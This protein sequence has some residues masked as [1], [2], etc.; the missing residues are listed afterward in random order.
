MLAG[1]ATYVHSSA[2]GA[3]LCVQKINITQGQLEGIRD[4]TSTPST[5]Y[6]SNNGFITRVGKKTFVNERWKKLSIM[7]KLIHFYSELAFD[8]NAKFGSITLH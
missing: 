7:E 8:L 2:F 4:N 5:K 6:L 1:F 3:G